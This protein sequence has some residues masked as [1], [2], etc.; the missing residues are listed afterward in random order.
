M[1]RLIVKNFGPLKSVDIEIKNINVFIGPTG[2]GKSTIAK[3]LAILTS[4]SFNFTKSPMFFRKNLLTYRID[5]YLNSKT[6]IKYEVDGVEWVYDKNSIVTNYK[7]AD[8]NLHS[9]KLIGFKKKNI[10]FSRLAQAQNQLRMLELQ[11]FDRKGM[12]NLIAKITKRIDAILK[13]YI[14]GSLVNISSLEIEDFQIL[15]EYLESISLKKESEFVPAERLFY[16]TFHN[17]LVSLYSQEINVPTFIGN[18]A[19][20]LETAQLINDDIHIEELGFGFRIINEILH[21]TQNGKDYIIDE[22]ASG[23]QSIMPIAYAVS[24]FKEQGLDSHLF[25]EEPELN[26]FPKAQYAIVKYIIRDWQ[27]SKRVFLTTHSPYILSALDNLISAG[28][29]GKENP[30]KTE[31]V[32]AK[33]YWLDYDNVNAYYFNP[34]PKRGKDNTENIMNADR[35][36][37]SGNVIDEVSDILNIEYEKLQEISSNG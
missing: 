33:N 1:E 36:G 7:L 34:E 13:R 6:Y 4:G 2:S 25:I 16:S 30:S 21:F 32:I 15:L 31:K 22:A 14:D 9:I 17:A 12:L 27:A 11:K 19:D 37:I 26:L 20:N 8:V 10:P 3:L 5:S 18:F 29:I 24:F 28:N 23:I 35:K